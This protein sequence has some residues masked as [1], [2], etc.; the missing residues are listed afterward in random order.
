M[1]TNVLVNKTLSLYGQLPEAVF[2]FGSDFLP[3]QELTAAIMKLNHRLADL[4]IIIISPVRNL[5]NAQLL[6][7]VMLVRVRKART[8]PNGTF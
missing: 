1:P 3:R 6:Q 5:Q 7:F 4:S 8:N 2:D